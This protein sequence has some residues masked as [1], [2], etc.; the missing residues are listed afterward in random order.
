M[1]RTNIVRPQG[2][3]NSYGVTKV[4]VDS[5]SETPAGLTEGHLTLEAALGLFW[6]VLPVLPC[7]GMPA[8]Q[9]APEKTFRDLIVFFFPRL[10]CNQI[11]RQNELAKP[12]PNEPLKNI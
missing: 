8:P 1:P 5:F 4:D 3:L 10:L 9:P 6:L 2:Y 11:P 7:L 12:S